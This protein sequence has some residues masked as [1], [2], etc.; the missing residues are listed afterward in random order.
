MAKNAEVAPAAKPRKAVQLFDETRR[1]A[2]DA[3]DLAEWISGETRFNI[4][5]IEYSPSRGAFEVVLTTA[6]V[7]GAVEVLTAAPEGVVARPAYPDDPVPPRKRPRVSADGTRV[8]L[9]DTGPQITDL[10]GDD[11]EGDEAVDDVPSQVAERTRARARR[12]RR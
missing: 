7:G 10:G 11:E 1:Y 8:E 3:A 9:P 5:R 4:Q 12:A 6:K 2:V